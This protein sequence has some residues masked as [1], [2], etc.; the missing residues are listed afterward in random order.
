MPADTSAPGALTLPESASWLRRIGALSV[1]WFA[2]TLVVISIVGVGDWAGGD[3]LAGTYA[4]GVYVVESAVL[5]TLLGGSFGKLLTGLRVIRT[6]GSG[7]VTLLPSLLRSLLVALV[8]PPLVFRP[9]GRGLH[10]VLVG[11][12]TVRVSDLRGSLAPPG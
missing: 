1:D 7:A 3:P 11:S 9:D 10:D 8:I 4:L 12:V 5:G 6:D 2:A